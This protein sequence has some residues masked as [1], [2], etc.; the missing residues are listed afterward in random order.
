MRFLRL[1]M[2]LDLKD[3]QKSIPIN[4][5]KD[6]INLYSSRFRS[7]DHDNKGYITVK[8]LRRYF[9]VSWKFPLI[10]ILII[11]FVENYQDVKVFRKC[12]MCECANF[13]MAIS[14]LTRVK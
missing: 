11:S 6:E 8:D 10:N 14:P 9:K 7:L 1:E 3:H 13:S 12:Q 5:T 2:G 4:F